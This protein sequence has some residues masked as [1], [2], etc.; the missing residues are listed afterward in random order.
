MSRTG[1]RQRCRPRGRVPCVC[2]VNRLHCSRHRFRGGLHAGRFGCIAAVIRTRAL[3]SPRSCLTFF[4]LDFERRAIKSLLK[5]QWLEDSYIDVFIPRRRPWV[6]TQ[7]ALGNTRD[8]AGMCRHCR[9]S[10]HL[11][12]SIGISTVDQRRSVC[13]VEACN[14]LLACMKDPI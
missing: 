12:T 4:L 6:R 7:E 10:T 1:E 3:C 14:V 5:I 13:T 2:V 9:I 11:M 8:S